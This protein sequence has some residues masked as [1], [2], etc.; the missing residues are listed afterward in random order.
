V[1]E[2]VRWAARQLRHGASAESHV[3]EVTGGT[4]TV[5]DVGLTEE[6]LT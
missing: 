3:F 4:E 1:A 2:P 5:I 6:P